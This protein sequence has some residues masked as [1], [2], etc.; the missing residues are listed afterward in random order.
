MFKPAVMGEPNKASRLQD[1][2]VAVPFGNG[3]EF[4]T[5]MPLGVFEVFTRRRERSK[6]WETALALLLEV[7]NR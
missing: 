7:A 5:P 4:A 2:P 3:I 6:R 1:G